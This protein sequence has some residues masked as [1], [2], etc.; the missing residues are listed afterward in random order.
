MKRRRVLPWLVLAGMLLGIPGLSRAAGL[1]VQVVEASNT[2]MG[3]DERLGPL[4]PQLRAFYR[5]TSFRLLERRVLSRDGG[6]VPMP[7]GR[8]VVVSRVDGRLRVKIQGK[9]RV[10]LEG[11]YRV[12]PGEPLLVG[13]PRHREGVLI[14]TIT[15]VP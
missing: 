6:T 11:T 13:G 14:V 4:L 8:R 2:A 1:E 12:A 10:L 15:A 5:Y 3:E 7:G 9:D